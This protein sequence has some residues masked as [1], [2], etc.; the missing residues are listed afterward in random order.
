VVVM[1]PGPWTGRSGGDPIPRGGVAR[2]DLRWLR[3][4]RGERAPH[5]NGCGMH[6]ARSIQE[7]A[8]CSSPFAVLRVTSRMLRLVVAHQTDRVALGIFHER[9]PFVHARRAQTVI[10]VTEDE[11]RLS[12]DLDTVNAQ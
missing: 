5:D 3:A 10:T 4:V 2:D 6:S 1:R 12:D 9:H 7:H 8:N 11:L